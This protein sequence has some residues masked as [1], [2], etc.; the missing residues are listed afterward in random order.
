MLSAEPKNINLPSPAALI[1]LLAFMT[2]LNSFC[3]DM[4]I[5]ALPAVGADLGI[6][7]W[8]TQQTISLFFVACAFASLWYGAIADTWG[9]RPTLFASLF[10]LGVAAAACVFAT[11]IEQLW[12]LRILQGLA[13]GA[14]LVLSR[15]ILH[16][17]H[18]GPDAQR[19]LSRITLIQTA[20]LLLTPSLGAWLSAHYGWRMVFAALA[21]I[22]LILAAAYWRWLPETLPR[23]GRLSLK[24][25]M[26][27]RAYLAALRTPRFVRLSLA[28]VA[29]WTSMALYVVSAPAIVVG[30]LGR[31]GTDIY[32]V[33]GP[34]TLGLTVGFWLFPRLLRRWQAGGTLAAAYLVLGTS[35]VLNLAAAW[36]WPAGIIHLAPLFAY[37]FGLAVALPILVSGAMEPLRQSAGV[38]A[39]CQTFL[40]YAMT[41]VAAG[42]LAPL[43]W[44]SLFSLALGIGGLTLAGGLAVLL[45]RRAERR[46]APE[47]IPCSETS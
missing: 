6:S 19:L 38:A 12:G 18:Q 46:P 10:M 4:L 42:L 17:L 32:L 2:L 15:S 33:Y 24:P 45:E 41:A 1:L 28:H 21:V 5:P 35:T 36:T 7:I 43:L 22:V 29:N 25:A 47:S 34:I 8:Q 26:L 30:L 23:D 20:S 27:G 9:R 39:S 11:G 40:Q 44:D 16:D 13:A 31:N 37:S 14:G 3:T